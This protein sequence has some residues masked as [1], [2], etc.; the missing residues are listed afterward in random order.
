MLLNC[1]KECASLLVMAAR[2]QIIKC[3]T[4]NSELKRFALDDIS[5][6]KM[7]GIDI[8]QNTE[9]KSSGKKAIFGSKVYFE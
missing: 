1:A 7:H 9:M 3:I 5:L 8:M 2:Q 4:N 6:I